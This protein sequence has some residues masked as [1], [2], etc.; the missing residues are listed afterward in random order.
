MLPKVL[1]VHFMGPANCFQVYRVRISEHFEA[2]VNN[3]ANDFIPADHKLEQQV[4]TG[5]R[6]LYRKTK[7]FDNAR[8]WF[9]FIDR[10]SASNIYTFGSQKFMEE[11]IFDNIEDQKKLVITGNTEIIQHMSVEKK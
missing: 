3:E 5:G 6:Y 4:F 1:M 2:L 11:Y 10:I 9:E 7:Y 8:S